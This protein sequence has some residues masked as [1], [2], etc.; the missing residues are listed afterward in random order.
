MSLALVAACS[1][2]PPVVPSGH[3]TFILSK[4][5]WGIQHTGSTVK[6]DALREANAYC[7]RMNKEMELVNSSQQDVVLFRSEAQA[8]IE[9]R[10]R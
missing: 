9:F 1:S 8:E 2:A 5:E 10:C 3:G 7:A 6:A 4:A